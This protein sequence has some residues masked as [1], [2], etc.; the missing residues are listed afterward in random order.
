VVNQEASMRT[1]AKILA[2]SVAAAFAAPAL[3]A[4]MGGGGGGGG[5]SIWPQGGAG[6]GMKGGGFAHAPAGVAARPRAGGSTFARSSGSPGIVAGQTTGSREFGGGG[7]DWRR[8][9][10]HHHHGFFPGPVFGFGY[11]YDNEPDIN[12]C[13]VPRRVYNARGVFI[14]WRRVDICAG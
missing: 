4:P 3:A 6:G 5:G 14:G 2:F 8:R 12:Q 10:H 7:D 13:W 1:L 11:D 9:H